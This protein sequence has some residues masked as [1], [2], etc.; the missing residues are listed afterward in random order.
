[1]CDEVHYTAKTKHK[2]MFAKGMNNLKIHKPLLYLHSIIKI[3]HM[4]I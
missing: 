1:M 2:I 3:D 4:L